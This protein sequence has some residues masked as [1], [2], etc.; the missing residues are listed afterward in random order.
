VA[1]VVLIGLFSVGLAVLLAALL[2]GA[3]LIGAILVLVLGGAVI[4]W[5]L[6]AGATRQ[7]P[8]DVARRTE[9]AEKPELLGPGGPDDPTAR[10]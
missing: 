9:K 5:L 7:A 6:L 3:G 4:A 2:P 8:S 1:A 10:R